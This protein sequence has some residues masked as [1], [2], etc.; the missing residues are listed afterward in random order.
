MN[1]VQNTPDTEKTEVRFLKV[2]EMSRRTENPHG[3]PSTYVNYPQI[4]LFGKWLASAG[5]EGGQT[6]KISVEEGRL[7]IE[8]PEARRARKQ[9]EGKLH[10][11][12]DQTPEPNAKSEDLPF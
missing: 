1:N 6:I 4:K 3:T 12:K 2:Y 11:P 8:N 5:F 9:A 7:I 10:S